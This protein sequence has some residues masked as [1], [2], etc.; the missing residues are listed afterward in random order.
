MIVTGSAKGTTLDALACMDG[1]FKGL[2]L[3][4]PAISDPELLHLKTQ[5]LTVS[6]QGKRT[7]WLVL[8]AH[9]RRFRIFF[10]GQRPTKPFVKRFSPIIRQNSTAGLRPAISRLA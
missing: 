3:L 2:S 8:C 7:S 6:H 1:R 10:F 9:E 4:D 5:A